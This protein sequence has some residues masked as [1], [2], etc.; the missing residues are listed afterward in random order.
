M[1]FYSH[2]KPKK[3]LDK[4]LRNVSIDMIKNLNINYENKKRN[5]ELVGLCHD[6]GKHTSFFQNT[7]NPIYSKKPEAYHSLLSALFCYYCIIKEKKKNLNA[8]DLDALI[9]FSVVKSHHGAIRR[10]DENLSFYK[11]QTLN[12]Q[13]NDLNKNFSS[14]KE[15]L[16]SL[17]LSR[18]FKDFLKKDIK[19]IY[20]SVTLNW[21]YF[22]YEEE[23]KLETYFYHMYLFSK[24]ISSDKLDASNT[25]MQ[26]IKSI[27]Y[28]KSKKYM[29]QIIENK[30]KK[31]TSRLNNI[32]NEIYKNV[33][34]TIRKNSKNIIYSLTSPTG[35]GKTYTG[36]M[37]A[38]V[39]QSENKEFKK[40][41]YTLPY[42]SIIEQNY[43]S[44]KD[45]ISG[46]NDFKDF[47]SNYLIKH[48]YLGDGRYK[49]K[50]EE[51]SLG[52]QN[53]LIEDWQSGVVVTTFVQLFQTI[54]GV[55]NKMVKKFHSL[56]NSIIIL[57]EIQA[58]DSDYY[59]LIEVVLK[60]LS[61]LLNIKIIIMTATKPYLLNDESFELL[62]DSNKYFNRLNRTKLIINIEETTIDFLIKD[63]KKRY[64]IKKDYLIVCNTIR[65]SLDVFE[66]INDFIKKNSEPGNHKVKYLSGNIVPVD[67]KK[68]IYEI[69]DI[70]ERNKEKVILVSTTSVEAGVDLDF[71]EVYKDISPLDSIIQCAGR[72]NRNNRLEQG[73]VYVYNL[74]DKNGKRFSSIYKNIDLVY[75]FFENYKAIEE[76]DYKQVIDDYFLKLDKY[77]GEGKGDSILKSMIELDFE[78]DFYK[79]KVSNFSL[80]ENYES[81]VDVLICNN[82][83]I[84]DN[85]IRLE[86]LY[87]DKRNNYDKIKDIKRQLLK[88]IISLPERY[89]RNLEKLKIIDTAIIRYKDINEFYNNETGFIRNN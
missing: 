27:N 11:L 32:R 30:K 47:E 23:K 58:I 73:L 16:N 29:T 18:Y 49:N 39:I 81:Y 50:N 25:K 59:K 74:I 54:I 36:Y 69:E 20:D 1:T 21:S 5:F 24:L 72:C 35:T 14:V 63:F 55:S 40:I 31:K 12:E 3:R 7:L 83:E 89:T 78:A 87:R 65:E 68:V 86:T 57:D 43:E 70:Q 51:I 10:I 17:G 53:L 76:K 26:V 56:D 44:I 13:N 66:Q 48:H 82:K 19:E 15:N 77:A 33:I 28:N 6:F 64:S 67:R 52:Q 2:T 45:L 34:D 41:I 79:P 71:D 37:A 4:H 75:D 22:K 60:K 80:I 85:I 84:E 8:Y 62:K 46:E 88:F 61:E 9:A 38:K 42:T